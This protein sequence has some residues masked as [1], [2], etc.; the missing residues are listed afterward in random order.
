MAER[1]QETYMQILMD[2]LKKKLGVL[3]EI[4]KITKKQEEENAK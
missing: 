4:Y 2:T 1:F 3:N